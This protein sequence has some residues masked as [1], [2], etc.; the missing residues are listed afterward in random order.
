M[1]S[2]CLVFGL[3]STIERE[4]MTEFFYTLFIRYLFIRIRVPTRASVEGIRV[5][6]Q[7]PTA[8]WH[9]EVGADLRRANKL[10]L[11]SS[12]LLPF[13]SLKR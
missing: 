8:H 4:F 2:D 12:P 1:D 6:P 5:E 7:P 3:Q 10:K 9:R 13:F 11:P